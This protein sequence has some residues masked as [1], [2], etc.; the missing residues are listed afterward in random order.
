MAHVAF[1]VKNNATVTC[2]VSD[3]SGK[4]M[5]S[6]KKAMSAGRNEFEIHTDNFAS[7]FYILKV[8]EGNSFRICKLSVIRM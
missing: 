4:L 1:N 8:N 7:G 5:F 2:T 6:E 3:L